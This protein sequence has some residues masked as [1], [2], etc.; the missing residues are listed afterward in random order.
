V[1]HRHAHVDYAEHARSFR[2]GRNDHREHDHHHD[3]GQR[4]DHVCPNDVDHDHNHHRQALH[5]ASDDDFDHD[6]HRPDDRTVQHDDDHGPRERRL[7][8]PIGRT[9]TNCE[10]RWPERAAGVRDGARSANRHLTIARVA[11]VAR[12]ARVAPMVTAA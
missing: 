1:H 12:S 3:S 4:A 10:S 5:G 7:R 2:N 6:D 8:G 11:P 9:S